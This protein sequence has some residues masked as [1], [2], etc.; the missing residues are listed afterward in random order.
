MNG[1]TVLIAHLIG[2]RL[3]VNGSA[4]VQ[5][6]MVA[7]GIKGPRAGGNE[8]AGCPLPAAYI[9]GSETLYRRLLHRACDVREHRI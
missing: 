1:H 8:L 9:C 3:L 4:G 2:A 7:T 5:V 6:G